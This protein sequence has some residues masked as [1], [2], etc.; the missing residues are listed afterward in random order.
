[1]IWTAVIVAMAA[2]QAGI[3]SPG[4]IKAIGPKQDDPLTCPTSPGGGGDGKNPIVVQGGIIVQGGRDRSFDL[5]PEDGEEVAAA[6]VSAW[7]LVHGFTLPALDGLAA[8]ET[9]METVRLTDM[10][11]RRFVKGL[12]RKHA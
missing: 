9:E 5:D 7:S 12:T 6:V 10:T 3:I 2:A 11:L 4:G 1:M 8:R